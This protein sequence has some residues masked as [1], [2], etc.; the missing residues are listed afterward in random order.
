MARCGGRFVSI[1]PRC[2]DV[3]DCLS[4]SELDRLIRPWLQKRYVAAK[5]LFDMRTGATDA[6]D[7]RANLLER[8]KRRQ[9]L[10]APCHVRHH[11]TAMILERKG[12]DDAKVTIVDSAPSK[13]TEADLNKMVAALRFSPARII[14]IAQQERGTNE[15]GVFVLLAAA[16]KARRRTL[17]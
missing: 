11:W 17:R 5:M 16:L 14:T 2:G 1:T 8:L 15:C 12:V 3:A 10:F 9:W 6:D 13:T 7:V 4:S